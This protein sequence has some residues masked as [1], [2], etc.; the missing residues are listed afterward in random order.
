MS[1][2][3]TPKFIPATGD[4][5][6]LERE[7]RFHPS[8]TEHPK[9]LAAEHIAAF[10]RHGYLKGIRIFS[11]R[12]IASIRAYFDELLARTLAAGGDSYSISTAHLR[13]GR[14]YDLLAHPRIVAH[15]ADLLGDNLI[16]WG[17]HFFCKTPTPVSWNNLGRY[18]SHSIAAGRRGRQI[19][20]GF[21]WVGVLRRRIPSSI[22][23]AWLDAAG[24]TTR[25]Q[26]RHRV[27]EPGGGLVRQV[28]KA[29]LGAPFRRRM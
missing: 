5:S 18:E 17:S 9:T 16:A 25:E 1:A 23:R 14:V 21:A 29:L 3:S 7:L 12:E 4:L 19:H 8:T 10:N 11:E 15:V 22:E 13:H 24:R 20:G 6:K 28:G 27:V 26:N 2:S